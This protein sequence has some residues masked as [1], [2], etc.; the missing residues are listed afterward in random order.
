MEPMTCSHCNEDALTDKAFAHCAA[1]PA[2]FVEPLRCP[3]CRHPAFPIDGI[4]QYTEAHGTPKFHNPELDD[5]ALEIMMAQYE[6]KEARARKRDVDQAHRDAR[7][8]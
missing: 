3:H 6:P 7:R 1:N 2:H 4:A 5:I 8:S